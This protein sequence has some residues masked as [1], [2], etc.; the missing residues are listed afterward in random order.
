[1]ARRLKQRETSHRGSANPTESAVAQS[2]PARVERSSNGS[3]RNGF[4]L[5]VY[6][7]DSSSLQT[8]TS[9]GCFAYLLAFPNIAFLRWGPHD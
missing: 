2:P 1:M 9:F 6:M 3:R 5:S 7:A 4:S 8:C